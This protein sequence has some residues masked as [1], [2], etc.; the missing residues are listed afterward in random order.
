MVIGFVM[1]LPQKGWRIGLSLTA[2]YFLA[3][4][5]LHKKMCDFTDFLV[6]KLTRS[7]LDGYLFQVEYLLIL[8][9]VLFLGWFIFKVRG[10]RSYLLFF[11]GAVGIAAYVAN[12]F[13]LVVHL[14]RI[15]YPQYALLAA[16]LLLWI[17]NAYCV[18]KIT[19]CLGIVDELYQWYFLSPNR[20]TTYID[21]NDMVLNLLGGLMGI[22]IV[23]SLKYL[24]EE[25]K[26]DYSK[27]GEGYQP[28]MNTLTPRKIYKIVVLSFLG[29]AIPSLVF[30]SL[31]VSVFQDVYQAFL[32]SYQV[33][34][35]NF[36]ITSSECLSYHVLTPIEG[37]CLLI[38]LLIASR[39]SM[40]RLT[41]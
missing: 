39:F 15:H 12:R 8:I 26:N 35:G 40:E 21:F 7:S 2:G 20:R 1:F 38:L 3:N 13:L 32:V 14:E 24:R 23:F 41:K 4:I 6:E 25:H 34:K 28:V 22:L 19:T 33:G 11:W 16:I 36:L 18:L 29:L 30:P 10:K 17:R 9:L 27:L 31:L 5:L 37:G